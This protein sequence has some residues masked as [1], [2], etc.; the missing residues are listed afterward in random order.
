MKLGN[1][2]MFRKPDGKL[3]IRGLAESIGILSIVLL[4]AGCSGYDFKP[5]LA[6]DY[7]AESDLSNGVVLV[8]VGA[9]P[10]PNLGWN[11]WSYYEFRSVN[12]PQR[13]GSLK[14]AK[15]HNFGFT[16]GCDDD[17][18]PKE[19]GQLFAIVLPAGEYEFF[20]VIPDLDTFQ[21]DSSNREYY[22]TPMEGYRFVVRPG[23]VDYLGNL[24][25]RICVG[26]SSGGG[27]RILSAIGDVAD[28]YDRDVPLLIDKFPQLTADVINNEVMT[29][30]PWLWR[31]KDGIDY[32]PA[33]SGT[34]PSN[35]SLD[36][37]NI[38]SYL[39]E[40]EE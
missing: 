5:G 6:A 19:C 27:N 29:G 20:R 10:E 35:C 16:S 22:D 30:L 31:Y 34:W 13:L 33:V 8:S 25:S 17:G 9:R 39:R 26:A 3:W 23:Q 18:L 37:N 11:A 24:L 32:T 2:R 15:K 36:P 12:D 21:Y 28:L 1:S 40:T 14:S 4:I 7:I 38:E